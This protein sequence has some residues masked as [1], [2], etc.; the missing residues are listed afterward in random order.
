MPLFGPYG[1]S[2]NLIF[3]SKVVPLDE[4]LILVVLRIGKWAVH[5]EE[6]NLNLVFFKMRR[7]V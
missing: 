2:K 4:F 3:K 7:F 6:S 1:K 5:K